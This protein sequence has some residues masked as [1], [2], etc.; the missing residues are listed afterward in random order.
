MALNLPWK[1]YLGWQPSPEER[2]QILQLGSAAGVAAASGSASPR[3]T[4]ASG[5]PSPGSVGSAELAFITGELE[6]SL[7][8]SLV[9]SDSATSAPTLVVASASPDHPRDDD[10]DPLATS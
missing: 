6:S 2:R 3:V 10:F 9:A 4:P 1:H 8:E 5:D 7:A